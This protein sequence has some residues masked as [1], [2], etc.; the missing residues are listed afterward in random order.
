VSGD[1]IDIHVIEIEVTHRHLHVE[2]VGHVLQ[3]AL[4]VLE[5]LQLRVHVN[6]SLVTCELGMG[7]EMLDETKGLRGRALIR[8]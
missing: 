1:I 4:A 5:L 2:L 3:R 7:N 6:Q 8:R